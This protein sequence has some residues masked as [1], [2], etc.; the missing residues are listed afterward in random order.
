VDAFGLQWTDQDA[1]DLIRG[2]MVAVLSA[3]LIGYVLRRQLG[4]KV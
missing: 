4:A 1:K 3:F 2:L